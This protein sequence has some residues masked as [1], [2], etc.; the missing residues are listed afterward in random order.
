MDIKTIILGLVT[1]AIAYAIITLLH[2]FTPTDKVKGY[3]KNEKTGELMNYR[4]NGERVLWRCLF[5]W[6]MLGI[7]GIVPFTWLYETRW[8]GLIG[9]VVIGLVFSFVVV[10]KHPSTGK[11]FLADLWFGRIKDAQVGQGFIDAKMWFYMIGAIML[12]LNVL[13]FAVA[14]IE[15]FARAGQINYGFLFGCVMLSWFC[16]DYLNFEKIHLWTYDFNAERTGFKLAFGCLGFYPYFYSVSLWFLA[17]K[18]NPGLQS[19]FLILV[20]VIFIGGW[21]TTRGA[22]MQ[23]YFFKLDPNK[24]FLCIKPQALTDGN[25]SLLVNGYWGVSRHINY[26]GE[27]LQAIAIALSAGYAFQLP[28]LMV[29]LYPAYYVGLLFTRAIDD[30]K[31]CKAKYGDL[32]D[33]YTKK[34][35]YKV[36]PFI[37]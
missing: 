23:K 30:G 25:H 2:I 27:I 37:W 14:H 12:Q 26:F 5:I 7:F 1:P 11:P 29:W 36:I 19:W 4:I 35:K 9:A 3:V 31:V 24:R 6:V 32:W 28:Y 20:C 17:D 16:W 13:S 22:N 15:M 33:Q 34:V 10:C 21:V 8:L 18:P